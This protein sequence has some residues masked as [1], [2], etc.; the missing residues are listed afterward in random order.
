MRQQGDASFLLDRHPPFSYIQLHPKARSYHSFLYFQPLNGTEVTV[1]SKRFE[2]HR[3]K[4]LFGGC[5]MH[6]DKV[7]GEGLHQGTVLKGTG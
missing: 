2:A 1:K 4:L 6:E 3:H 7:I 5:F